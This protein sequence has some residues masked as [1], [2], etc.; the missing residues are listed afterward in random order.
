[1]SE[2]VKD[3]ETGRYL[4][5]EAPDVSLLCWKDFPGVTTVLRNM[6]KTMSKHCKFYPIEELNVE[7]LPRAFFDSKK[8]ILGGWEPSFYPT[9]CERRNGVSVLLCS[10]LGQMDMSL[11][12][13]DYLA[14]IVSL[15]HKN[16][17]DS[18][19]TGS[20]EVYYAFRSLIPGLIW[21]PYPVDLQE[22]HNFEYKSKGSYDVGFF[23]PSHFR[24]NISNQL[25]A[26]SYAKELMK[27]SN[28]KLKSVTVTTNIPKLKIPGVSVFEKGW[29]RRSEYLRIIKSMRLGLHVTFTE[30]FGY[31]AL[32]YLLSGVPVLMSSTVGINLR[33]S[34]LL[35]KELVVFNPDGVREMAQAIIRLCMLDEEE[36]K[37]LSNACWVHGRSLSKEQNLEFAKWMADFVR[38]EEK[39]FGKTD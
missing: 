22:F 8:V 34:E 35:S 12:E 25:Y 11:I 36:Y 20:I 1:M 24:K 16:I 21:V 13:M 33:L 32:D 30:S 10:S 26:V 14:Q 38:E 19:I 6:E 39:S 18:V 9:L 37:L 27:E 31:A 5:Q 2:K 29:M 15:K 23:L 28:D 17:V 4:K 3:P 7:K